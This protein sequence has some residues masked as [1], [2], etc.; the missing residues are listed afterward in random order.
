MPYEIKLKQK[1]MGY[2]KGSA[3]EG[4]LATVVAREFLSSEDG[5]RFF[6]RMDGWPSEIV[7]F[8]I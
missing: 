7:F 4:Q 1:P 5:E 3:L 2:A 8:T 6:V